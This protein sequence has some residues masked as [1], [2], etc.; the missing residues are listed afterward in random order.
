MIIRGISGPI[1]LELSSALK[2]VE[3][4]HEWLMT[5]FKPDALK[6]NTIPSKYFLLRFLS[7]LWYFTIPEGI[8]PY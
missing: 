4:L 5:N 6:S 1:Y 8:A 3:D 7:K 2:S